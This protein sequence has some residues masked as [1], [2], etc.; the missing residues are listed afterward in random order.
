MAPNDC[1]VCVCSGQTLRWLPT[2]FLLAVK[3]SRCPQA[4]KQ[5]FG[6]LVAIVNFNARETG[7]EINSLS[8]IGG[9]I[10]Q[11]LNSLTLH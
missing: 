2:T 7:G 3:D 1:S 5:R 8:S 10:V 9:S 6:T 11:K 4:A